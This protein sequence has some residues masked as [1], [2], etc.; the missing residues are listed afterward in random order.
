MHEDLDDAMEE[1]LNGTYQEAKTMLQR[2]RKALDEMV[3]ALLKKN[4]LDGSEVRE[5]IKDHACPDDLFKY[6]QE[7]TPFL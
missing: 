1:K 6:E 3:L 4:I 2:N 7:K 5:I